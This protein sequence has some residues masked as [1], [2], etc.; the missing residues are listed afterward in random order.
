MNILREIRRTKEKSMPIRI[1]LTLMFCVIFIVNT[2]AWFGLNQS[3][4]LT[5]IS[6]E[7]TSWDIA[8]DIED[9]ETLDKTATF[10]IDELYPGMT[11]N[12][13]VVRICNKGGSIT[14]IDYELLSVKVFGVEILD[15]LKANQEI[16][17]NGNTTNIFSTDA[18]YPFDISYTYGS[19]YLQGQYIDDET[20]PSAVT[21]FKFNVSWPYTEGTTEEE[22]AAKDILDTRFGIKAY[23]YY[24]LGND[25][26]SAVEVKV[27]ITSEVLPST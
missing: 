16:T 25:K 19:N 27:R 10:V 21:T 23:D 6:G 7:V 24:E 8:Y 14:T 13:D 2:Y 22:T 20:T 1:I 9:G 11:E 15:E 4:N 26:H 18:N 5:G 12:Q 17:T 3:V